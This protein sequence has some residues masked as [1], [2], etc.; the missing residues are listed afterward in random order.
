[1]LNDQITALIVFP[2]S[3]LTYIL[4]SPPYILTTILRIDDD[5]GQTT[6]N[7]R[8]F[9]FRQPKY[10][11]VRSCLILTFPFRL[12]EEICRF[13][14]C[15]DGDKILQIFPSIVVNTKQRKILTHSSSYS[16]AIVYFLN[17]FEIQFPNDCT[18]CTMRK[19][20]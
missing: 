1:M 20:N 12:H 11:T 8:L 17:L 19:L 4:L 2:L 16:L 14:D 7:T 10:C 6:L 9:N 15:A 3:N 13:R 5:S 18:I